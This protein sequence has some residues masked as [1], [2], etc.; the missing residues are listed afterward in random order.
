MSYR[1]LPFVAV[2]LTG[3]AYGL[4]EMAQAGEPQM[5]AR[6]VVRD[7]LGM[8]G[9]P[10][11]LEARLISQG[12]IGGSALGG[13]QV[14]FQVGGAKVGTGLTGG[15]GVARLEYR[16]RLAGNHPVTVRLI[17]SKRVTGAHEGTAVLSVWEKRRPIL[18]VELASLMEP[19]STPGLSL[20]V[21]LPVGTLTERKPMPDA[22]AE[23]KNLSQFYFN[24][25][26]VS[27]GQPGDVWGRAGDPREWLKAH[28]FPSGHWMVVPDGKEGLKQAIER[29]KGD[30]WDN[31][32][33]GIGRSKDFAEVLAGQRLAVVIVPEPQRGELPRKAKTAKEWKEIRKNF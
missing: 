33:T 11:P 21:P 13:E 15:D 1:Q 6:V 28:Q 25:L 22:A 4:T 29:L 17:P 26:Y 9:K 12:L 14:E 27:T 5:D 18:L 8:V 23:L 19:E 31:M 3:L 2:V 24:L 7:A 30:G 20:P 10:V 32:R 16:T